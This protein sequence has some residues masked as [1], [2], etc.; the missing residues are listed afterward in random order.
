MF[1]IFTEA[2]KWTTSRQVLVTTALVGCLLLICAALFRCFFSIDDLGPLAAHLYQI[3]SNNG[4]TLYLSQLSFT[5][6]TISVM[7]VLSDTS[8]IIYWENIV[9][10]KLIAP[11]WRCFYA[12]T[13]YS[14]ATVV[15]GGIA[16]L[17]GYSALYLLLFI[18]D[19]FVLMALTFSMIDVYFKHDD[20]AL[21][22]ERE[23]IRFARENDSEKTYEQLSEEIKKYRM[24]TGRLKTNTILALK[25]Y[26]SEKIEENFRFYARNA[27]YI[28]QN[29]FASIL[30]C[31]DE[32]NLADYLSFFEYYADIAF[33]DKAH[34]CEYADNALSAWMC[35]K[36]DLFS[37]LLDVH[38][39]SKFMRI[40]DK[41]SIERIFEA[42]KIY[43]K[44]ERNKTKERLGDSYDRK[45]DGP[46]ASY[47]RN[48]LLE[49]LLAA[50]KEEL[51][52]VLRGL[53]SS[54]EETNI[55]SNYDYNESDVFI[56]KKFFE[57]VS[58][59]RL[60]SVFDMTMP[61]RE[62][63]YGATY[64]SSVMEALDNAVDDI[65]EYV[66]IYHSFGHRSSDDKYDD[67]DDFPEEDCDNED[68]E[69]D[70][71]PETDGYGPASYAGALNY[72]MSESWG[73]MWDDD[74]CN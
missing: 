13:T 67:V 62:I 11:V 15:F 21:R 48:L 6:I 2:K 36:T 66:P 42:Y 49:S 51:N 55:L 74:T 22:L 73:E 35:G 50:A 8:V 59:D 27:I 72:G 5:F 47:S 53:L 30:N 23:F 44:K 12:Y 71:P 52:D 54:F 29:D 70:W 28:P 38:V 33:T 39:F 58:K 40:C 60:E 61:I 26:D 32:V 37:I 17:L 46:A 19:V 14:F 43:L 64:P 34:S 25:N 1:K 3:G 45:K 9:R 24:V 31:V 65:E 41:S 63:L 18:T 4:L 10:Q 16:A 20:K 7:S 56:W 68:S 57:S 69:D